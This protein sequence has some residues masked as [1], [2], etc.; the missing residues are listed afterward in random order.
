MGQWS[1]RF[2]SDKG[3][4]P[5]WLTVEVQDEQQTAEIELEEAALDAKL[6]G[7][8]ELDKGSVIR[9]DHTA[10]SAQPPEADAE[11]PQS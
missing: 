6:G 5:V 8:W 9:G 1:G 7:E 10:G 2:I 4:E 3:R 11:E